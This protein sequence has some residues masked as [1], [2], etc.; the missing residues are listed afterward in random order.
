MRKLI[1]IGSWIYLAMGLVFLG[2]DIVLGEIAKATVGYSIAFIV[3]GGLGVRAYKR[4]GPYNL[5]FALN[6]I[7]VLVGVVS[8]SVEIPRNGI[9]AD[10]LM[11]VVLA[12]PALL[13]LVGVY[14]GTR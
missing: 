4:R 9:R 5:V 12:V 6:T 10:D 1:P 2:M 13:V 14:G 8:L 11:I 7:V 3:V